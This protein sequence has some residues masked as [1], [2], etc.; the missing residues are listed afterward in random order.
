VSV[1]TEDE[2]LDLA[3]LPFAPLSRIAGYWAGTYGAGMG[4]KDQSDE[5]KKLR[6]KLAW[7]HSQAEE[8]ESGRPELHT[9]NGIVAAKRC[10][11]IAAKYRQQ[12]ANLMAIIDATEGAIP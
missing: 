3:L 1:P 8:Y 6:Q 10:A 4:A 12:A 7:L 5:L 2:W 11:E 9:E